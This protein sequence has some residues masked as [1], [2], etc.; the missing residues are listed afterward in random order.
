MVVT[1][2]MAMAMATSALGQSHDH[3]IGADPY[4]TWQ[5]PKTGLSY[6]S[7]KDCGPWPATDI[8]PMKDGSFYLRSLRVEVQSDRVLPSPD[9]QYHVCCRRPTG[10]SPCDTSITGAP[11]IYCMAAPMGY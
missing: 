3:P 10:Q 6:C 4:A 7:G 8:D 11:E 9:G 2:L 1:A 5:Q